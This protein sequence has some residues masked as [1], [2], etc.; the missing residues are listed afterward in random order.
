MTSNT[1]RNFLAVTLCSACHWVYAGVPEPDFIVYGK[2]T[3]TGGIQPIAIDQGTLRWQLSGAGKELS[4]ETDVEIF[5]SDTTFSYRI[6]FPAEVGFP[7]FPS[8]TTVD[9][10]GDGERYATSTI[11]LEY[12]GQIYSVNVDR[13]D[14]DAM[15]LEQDQRGRNFRID[16]DVHLPQLDSDGDGMPDSYEDQYDGLDKLVADADDDLDGDSVTNGD[17]Y[18]QQTDPSV[19]DTAPTIISDR[20]NAIFGGAVALRI[21]IADLDDNPTINALAPDLSD[22]ADVVITLD[23]ISANFALQK[24]TAGAGSGIDAYQT[25]AVGSTFTLAE[26]YNGQI[27]LTHDASDILDGVI[28]ISVTDSTGGSDSADIP[29]KVWNPAGPDGDDIL[30]WIDATASTV[31]IFGKSVVTGEVNGRTSILF[32]GATRY[33]TSTKGWLADDGWHISAAFTSESAEKQ[34]LYNTPRGGLRLYAFD[35]LLFPGHLKLT[36]SNQSLVS[37]SSTSMG[38]LTLLSA[39]MHDGERGFSVNDSSPAGSFELA[40]DNTLS[41]LDEIGG[42]ATNGYF[43]GG[44]HELMIFADELN[45]YD[46]ADQQSYLKARWENSIIVDALQSTRPVFFIA[47]SALLSEDDYTSN[48]TPNYGEAVSHILLGW[49]RNVVAYGGYADD[50]FW[51]GGGNSWLAGGIGADQFTYL[52]GGEEQVIADFNESEGDT[53]ALQYLFNGIVSDEIEKFVNIREDESDALVE[54]FLQG[55]N[56]LDPD[57]V[58]RLLNRSDL[59]QSQ[60][61]SLYAMGAIDCG[62]VRPALELQMNTIDG[63]AVEVDDSPAKIGVTLVEGIWPEGKYVHLDLDTDQV[64]GE[65]F[66]LFANLYDPNLGAY[67][68]TELFDYRVPVSLKENDKVIQVSI[69]PISNQQ[70]EPERTIA[71]N[72]IPQPNRFTLDETFAAAEVTIIDGLPYLIIQPTIAELNPTLS[73]EGFRITRVGVTDVPL[74]FDVVMEGTAINGTDYS[75]VSTQHTLPSGSEEILIPINA[76]R[77]AQSQGSNVVALRLASGTKYQ[78]ESSTT[79]QIILTTEAIVI[80]IDAVQP[81]AVVSDNNPEALIFLQLTGQ[82]SSNVTMVPVEFHGNAKLSEYSISVINTQGS[83]LP[84]SIN[85]VTRS[86]NIFLLPGETYAMIKLVPKSSIDLSGGKKYVDVNLGDP[87]SGSTYSVGNRDEVT[88]Y[89]VGDFSTWAQANNNGE[90]I[91]DLGQW[92]SQTANGQG[93]SNLLA[94]AFGLDPQ[95]P[96]IAQA[97][98]FFERNTN[99]NLELWMPYYPGAVGVEVELQQSLSLGNDWGATTMTPVRSEVRNGQDYQVYNQDSEPQ[100]AAFYRVQ[101]D[102]VE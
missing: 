15:R 26:I 69:Q 39:S 88:L 74:T 4:F 58:V 56:T 67:V 42:N 98:I 49:N 93:V 52:S 84:L 81:K 5:G 6:S 87:A 3:D 30:A 48:F 25:L 82:P 10:E 94:Y 21:D 55:D 90:A 86:G 32:D 64:L 17:E 57:L 71:V 44:L 91:D 65:D 62:S 51:V 78:L 24:I 2:I 95:N 60:L 59:D 80:N 18:A 46:F 72:A 27:L 34:Q 101:V 8:K 33:T 66:R 85:S 77:Y 45:D 99:Q 41:A 68:L 92:A 83:E 63:E 16:L 19:A 61:A 14:S 29:I 89:I 50:E 40:N 31:D 102:L 23:A 11:E 96:T 47:P 37:E 20:L 43:Q 22:Q 70:T 28:S 79:A 100:D 35:D 73:G 9:L 12:L 13:S 1:F 75:Y 97:G 54:V 38:E 53:L 36:G 76:L 7:S